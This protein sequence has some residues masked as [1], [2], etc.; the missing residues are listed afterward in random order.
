MVE[1]QEQRSRTMR[2]VGSCDTLPE[3][4]VRTLLRKLGFKGYRLHR[5]EVPGNPDIV[6]LGRRKVIF[7]HGCFW[8]GHGCRRGKRAPVHNASYWQQ[9]IERNRLRDAKHVVDLR[10][11]N[12]SILVIW[13]CELRAEAALRA[14][15]R[16]F[17]RPGKGDGKRKKGAGEG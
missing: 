16:C 1:S 15:V 11:S 6:F 4:A 10:R 2:A 14:R 17:M 8:H 7:V 13:E 9:K 3:I 12:W 5:K